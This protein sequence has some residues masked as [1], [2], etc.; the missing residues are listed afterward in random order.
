MERNSFSVLFFIKKTKLLKNGEASVCM[1]ITVNGVRVENNIR[2][3]IEPASWNQAKECARGKNRKAQELNSYIEEARIRLHRLCSN[4][5]EQKQPVTARLLQEKFF[6]QNE[7]PEEIR[8]IIGTMTEHNEQCRALVG[9]DYALIT[10]RRYDNCKKY[11][12]EVIRYKYAKDDLPLTEVNGELVRAFEFYLKTERE[13]QQNTVIRYMKCLKKIINLALSNE[14]ITKNPF[15]GIK[16]HE[17]EVIREFLTIDELMR[18]YNKEFELDRITLVRDV[19]IFAA[20]TGLAFID[21]QQLS[22]EHIIKDNNGHYWIRKARQKTNNMCN[23]PLLD[24]PMQILNKYSNNPQCL[25]K[26][27]LLPVPCNQKMNSYL[28]EIADLCNIN[29][30]MSTHTARHSYATSVCLANG[31][32]I[33][34]VAKMLGHSNIKMT[35]HYAKVMDSSILKD[36]MNVKSALSKVI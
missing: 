35:Q 21:V 36:M 7:K 16:F 8:T 14:W 30:R 11:L 2:M 28:K 25:K 9:K 20:F 31:V 13:C 33:E 4:M 5:E 27:V 6:R 17:K 12:N 23:I 22:A 34:N 15:L 19:F 24:I 29:K 10:V 1:R 18:I 32:S 26:Q 3:S